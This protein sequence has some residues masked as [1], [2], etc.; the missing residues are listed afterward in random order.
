MP[1]TPPYHFVWVAHNSPAYL[2]T[3]A[4]RDAVLRR[5]LGLQFTPE[6]LATEADQ[7]HLAGYLN[8]SADENAL[9]S[10]VCCLILQKT[11]L[12]SRIKMRQVAVVEILQKQ[13]IGGALCQFA[14]QWAAQQGYAYIYCHARDIAVPFYQKLGYQIEGA[15]FTEVGIKH[16]KMFKKLAAV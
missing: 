2:Q 9:P 4:L 7:Y 3:V 11:D 5:P 12:S 16:Y 1:P 13:G 8:L 6:Q 15:P 10:I 14:E